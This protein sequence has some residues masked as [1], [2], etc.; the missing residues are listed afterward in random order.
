MKIIIWALNSHIGRGALA[1]QIA[2]K[3]WAVFSTRNGNNKYTLLDYLCCVALPQG[4]TALSPKV[5]A[6]IDGSLEAYS[7]SL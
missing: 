2:A 6:P 7:A 1:I 5:M 4:M 3:P